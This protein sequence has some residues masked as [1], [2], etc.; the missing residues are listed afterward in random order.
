MA[1]TL[2]QLL[3]VSNLLTAAETAVQSGRL[4]AREQAALTEAIG[5]ATHVFSPA[6]RRVDVT[7][8][9]ASRKGGEAI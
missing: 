7:T 6:S 9:S 8:R 5:L 4:L 2:T 1:P 3:A